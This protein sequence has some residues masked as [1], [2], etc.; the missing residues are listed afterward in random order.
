MAANTVHVNNIA[1]KTDDK[2]VKDFFSFWY[3][4]YSPPLPLLSHHTNP[5]QRQNHLNQRNPLHNRHR[6][7]IRQRNLR[8]RNRRWGGLVW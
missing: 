5:P 7:Q 6:P 1:A 4:P 3:A 2:E 8:E